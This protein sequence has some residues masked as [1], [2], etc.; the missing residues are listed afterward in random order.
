DE[1]LVAIT[2]VNRGPGP[3][4]LHVLPTLWFRNSW[5]GA[6]G[7]SRPVLRRVPGPPGTSAV[8]ATHAELGRRYLLAEGAAPL[9][10]TANATDTARITGAPSAS[11]YVKDGIDRYLVH[12]EAPAVNPAGA[13]TKVA[14][15]YQLRLAAGE[16]RT[17]RLRLGP[18]APPG[19]GQPFAAAFDETM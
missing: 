14:V 2:A 9:L 17:L 7:T 1:L 5:A 18:G 3:A 6:D 16:G 11:P 13:G 8:E 12:G 19:A 10:F 4:L 15:H